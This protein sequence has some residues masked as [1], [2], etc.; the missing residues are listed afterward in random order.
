MNLATGDIT[1]DGFDVQ[2][3]NPTGLGAAFG[4]TYYSAQARANH[5]SPGPAAGW[6]HNYDITIT[7]NGQA[8]AIN[9][10]NGAQEPITVNL[11]GNPQL[12]PPADDPMTMAGI[13]DAGTQ[14][15]T[16]VQFT[17][18]S[19]I[20]WTFTQSAPGSL[21]LTSM[22]DNTKLDP[23]SNLPL[24]VSLSGQRAPPHRHHRFQRQTT[25]CARLSHRHARQ[26]RGCSC[27]ATPSP[28]P[29][30]IIPIIS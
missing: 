12:A 27:R 4:G 11:G 8:L 14:L 16:Q 19:N 25:H 9:Y 24:A 17:D 5:S 28:R 23:V 3:D 21:Q 2:V 30:V 22:T 15:W 18:K 26:C 7:Q 10:P 20:T 13:Y 1:F 6:T 29:S